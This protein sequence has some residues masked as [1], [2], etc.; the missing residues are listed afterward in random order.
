MAS[1]VDQSKMMSFPP[2]HEQAMNSVE[3]SLNTVSGS[4]WGYWVYKNK[5][6]KREK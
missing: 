2:K 6:K 1:S 3:C 4:E 5:Y